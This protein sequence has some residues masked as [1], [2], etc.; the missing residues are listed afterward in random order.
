M[1]KNFKNIF[2]N[3]LCRLTSTKSPGGSDSP[4][5]LRT[6]FNLPLAKYYLLCYNILNHVII[7]YFHYNYN[8]SVFFYIFG[9]NTWL[10]SHC[11][12]NVMKI[13]LN[14]VVAFK[15]MYFSCVVLC[16][17]LFILKE[18]YIKKFPNVTQCIKCMASSSRQTK[19]SV[20]LLC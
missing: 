18:E 9:K 10:F 8:G 4:G 7:K 11:Y 1:R 17:A 6:P 13:H 16:H 15:V 3:V 19:K 20:Q 2:L 12:Y 14:C 5:P